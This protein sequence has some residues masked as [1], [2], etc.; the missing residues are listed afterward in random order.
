MLQGFHWNSAHEGEWYNN[1]CERTNDLK[2]AGVSHVWLPPPSNSVAPEGYLPQ[3]WFDLNTPYGSEEELRCLIDNLK[4]AGITPMADIVLNHRCADEQSTGGTWNHYSNKGFQRIS[5]T[6][7]IDEA[8]YDSWDEDEIAGN[9]EKFG[10]KGHHAKGIFDGAPDLDHDSPKVRTA[11]VAWLKWLSR[12]VGFQGWRFDFAKGYDAKH[13]A[14]Y[15]HAT[16][17]E[18]WLNVGEMWPEADW[19]SEGLAHNQDAMRQAICDFVSS[20]EEC[21]SAFDFT[22]KAILQVAVSNCEYSRLADQDRK[23]PGLLGW[24]PKRA[25]T[26]VDNHDTGNADHGYAQD[27]KIKILKAEDDIYVADIAGEN[28]S[29]RVKMGPRFDMDELAPLESW[30]LVTCGEDYAVWIMN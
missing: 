30:P 5:R 4:D 17:N 1:V 24:W 16:S 21:T 26:F 22:T 27:S 6:P 7:S 28:C 14:S 2:H 23:P 25:V 12:D 11:V 3:D 20:C 8:F 18:K 15:V 19:R 9:D 29:M 10:G 13:I